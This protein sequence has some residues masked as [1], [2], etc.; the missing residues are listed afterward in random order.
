[1]PGLAAVV[2]LSLVVLL[3]QTDALPYPNPDYSTEVIAADGEPLRLYTTRDGYWRL[4][5][6]SEAVDRRFI[7]ML[8][9]YEDQRFF[10][11]PGVDPLALVRAA[12][13]ALV[14]GRVVSGASTLSMQV[15]RLLQPRPRNLGNKLLEMWRALLLEQRLSKREIL[16]LYLSLAPYGGNLQGLRA[17]SRFYFA[18]EPRFLTTAEAALLVALPQSPERRRPDRHPRAALAARNAVL[19]RLVGEGVLSEA[20][21]A[22]AASRPLPRSR[23]PAPGLAPHLADRLRA[24]RPGPKPIRTAVNAGLQRRLQAIALRYQAGLADGLTVAALVL[25][26]DSGG[27]LAYLGSGDYFANR[28]PGQVDMVRA[29]R[30]PGSALKP[31]IYGLGFDAGFLHPETLVNDRPGLT[32]GYDPANYDRRYEG[33]LSVREAL[34]RSRNVPAVR[35]LQRLGPAR[36]LRHMER[37]GVALRLPGSSQQPG[38]PIALGGVGISLEQLVGLYASLAQR[39]DGGALSRAAAWYVTDILR[40]SPLPA[41]FLRREPGIAFKTG[42]SYG[43]RDAWAVGYDAGHTVGVWV[44]RPDGGYTSGLSGLEAAVPVMLAVFDQLPR[45]GLAPLLAAPPEG[46]LRVASNELP[47]SLRRLDAAV[48]DSGTQQPGPRILYPPEGARVAVEEDGELLLEIRGGRGPF[49]WLVQGRYLGSVTQ[50]RSSPWVPPVEGAVRLTVIDSAGRSDSVRFRVL[51][52][53]A[54]PSTASGAGPGRT[55]SAP[56]G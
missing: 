11:H 24:D 23:L 35:V 17:A 53:G 49:H 12:W 9:T 56:S 27:T 42:T 34:Q 21:A 3:C 46:V 38:L 47:E 55:S 22:R 14:N 39:P 19:G 15:V 30:S 2:L 28:F 29:M 8:L 7:R 26:N 10:S 51:R 45:A 33:E 1:V 25:D 37:A 54:A 13:Q 40:G 4:P 52:A 20:Q 48:P 41:G 50:Q 18:K 43:F 5:V 36:F 6:D 31:F 32:A 44:G 16:D